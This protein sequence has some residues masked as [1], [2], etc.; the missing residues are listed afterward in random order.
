MKKI[1][2]RSRETKPTP[3]TKDLPAISIGDDSATENAGRNAFI[4]PGDLYPNSSGNPPELDKLNP[5]VLKKNILELKK[6]NLNI[7]ESNFLNFMLK[8]MAQAE[9]I[10]YEKLFMEDMF[11]LSASNEIRAT[12][13]IN[14]LVMLFS[15]NKKKLD[16]AG[17]DEESSLKKSYDLVKSRY[18]IKKVSQVVNESDPK[19]VA[20]HITNIILIMF[21]RFSINS[22][23]KARSNIKRRVSNLNVQDM[24]M[25][26]AP[27]GAAIGTSIALVKNIL[28]GKDPY[29]IRTV[30]DEM[31]KYI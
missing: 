6:K 5:N 21:S 23:V 11:N 14:D 19:A 9:D 28:N 22:R 18:P 30:I 26:K 8:K 25:K 13:Y 24:S 29:F 12:E 7:I 20:K 1:S 2:Y 17:E 15:Q 4:M 31:K 10:S 16:D 3:V 27:A